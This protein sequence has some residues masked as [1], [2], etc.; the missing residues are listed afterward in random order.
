MNADAPSVHETRVVLTASDLDATVRLLQEGLG[1]HVLDTWNDPNGRGVVL[2]AGSA[3]IEVIDVLQAERL[4]DVEAAGQRSGTVRLAFRVDDVPTASRD[5]RG[6]GARSLHEPV[7]TPWGLNQR[8]THAG[9]HLTLFDPAT[10][11]ERP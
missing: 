2:A 9:L 8:L 4:D 5:L 11:P 3:T 6:A 10:L 7:R 1:L